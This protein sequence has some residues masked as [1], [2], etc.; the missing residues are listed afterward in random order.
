MAPEEGGLT[1]KVRVRYKA[2]P[3]PAVD[4]LKE[5]ATGRITYEEYARR[6]VAM[7]KEHLLQ[8]PSTIPPELTP[9]PGG[10]EC[11]GNGHWPGYEC[12]CPDCDWYETVCFPDWEGHKPEKAEK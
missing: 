5:Y 7:G 9:S 2:P 4:A 12:Q 1:V 11:L 10:R 6:L 3:M 8:E